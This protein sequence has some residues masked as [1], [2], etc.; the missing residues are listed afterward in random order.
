MGEW[1]IDQNTNHIETRNDWA[2]TVV[3]YVQ[4]CSKESTAAMGIKKLGIQGTRQEKNIHVILIG[5][6]EEFDARNF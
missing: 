4:A 1:K 5:E 3:I 2:R 6:F